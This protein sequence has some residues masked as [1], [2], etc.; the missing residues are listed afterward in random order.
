MVLIFAKLFIWAIANWE[1]AELLSHPCLNS[2]IVIEAAVFWDN[3][4]KEDFPKSAVIYDH[5]C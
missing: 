2:G 4:R 5:V 1:R 3:F